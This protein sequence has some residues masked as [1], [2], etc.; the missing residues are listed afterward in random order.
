MLVYFIVGWC[1]LLR[2]A[3]DASCYISLQGTN[4]AGS[5][6]RSRVQ[7][8]GIHGSAQQK[9][10]TDARLVHCTPAYLPVV[11]EAPFNSNWLE[12]LSLSPAGASTAAAEAA[13]ASNAA[14]RRSVV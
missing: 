3:V 5:L 7:I 8:P 4:P 6:E 11:L 9:R 1:I 2:I 12:Q 13:A 14:A 10:K